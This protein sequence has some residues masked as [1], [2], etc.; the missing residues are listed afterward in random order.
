[1]TATEPEITARESRK[2]DTDLPSES[3]QRALSLALPADVARHIARRGGHRS[4]D[5]SPGLRDAVSTAL[6]QHRIDRVLDL[7]RRNGSSREQRAPLSPRRGLDARGAIALALHASMDTGT[8]DLCDLLGGSP[9]RLGIDLFQARAALLNGRAADSCN[10]PRSL[11]GRL[12]DADLTLQERM[13]LR[14]HLRECPNCGALADRFELLDRDL[15][16]RAE[17]AGSSDGGRDW[18]PWLRRQPGSAFAPAIALLVCLVVVITA[19]AYAGAGQIL[20][21]GGGPIVL[22][23]P[24]VDNGLSGWLV[25]STVDG[26][27]AINL[28]TR[29]HRVLARAPRDQTQPPVTLLSPDGSRI[30]LWRFHDDHRI[31][32][33]LEVTSITGEVLGTWRW[34]RATSPGRLT[35][36]LNDHEL[37]FV[38]P[39]AQQ[40]GE[41]TQD[42]ILRQTEVNQLVALDVDARQIRHLFT[43]SVAL[44][45]PSP[46]Q[47]HVAILGI[48]TTTAGLPGRTLEIRPVAGDNLGD[49]VAIQENRYPLEGTRPIWSEDGSLVFFTRLSD[50]SPFGAA[51]ARR[52]ERV[53]VAMLDL[54]GN[55]A[56][57]TDN[58]EHERVRLLGVSPDASEFL[59]LLSSSTTVPVTWNLW[60]GTVGEGAHDML[61]EDIASPFFYAST[62]TWLP[63]G[64]TA[65]VNESQMHFLNGDATSRAVPV[66]ATRF[67]AIRGD[68]VRVISTELGVWGIDAWGEQTLRWVAEIAPGDAVARTPE[69]IA[70]VFSP[71]EVIDDDAALRL[72]AS[73]SLPSP[74][75]THVLYRHG[76]IDVPIIWS[77]TGRSGRILSGNLPPTDIAWSAGGDAV[78]GVQDDLDYGSRLVFYATQTS[79]VANFF[80]YRALDPAGIRDDP[81]ARYAAPRLAPDGTSIS[82]VILWDDERSGELWIATLDG[83]HRIAH[84]WSTPA[85]A[86][87][88][89]PVLAHWTSPSTI[90]VATPL[91]WRSGYPLEIELTQ[92]SIDAGE[93]VSA[94]RVMTF[95]APG[96][97][98][99]LTLE[100]M[101]FSPDREYLALR[102]RYYGSSDPDRR[103]QD[104]V[105]V[106]SSHDARQSVE[107]TRGDPGH[108][109]A[110]SPDSRWLA[111]GTRDRIAVATVDGRNFRFI[112]NDGERAR[113]PVWDA[114]GQIHYTAGNLHNESLIVVLAR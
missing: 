68:E 107:L 28:A 19:S 4:Q 91:R 65:V 89:Q 79:R 88:E 16:A 12:R 1:M 9:E 59:Y 44:A 42:F 39:P 31:T 77:Q 47:R 78:I 3:L 46:D 92:I 86:K 103:Q 45:T 29:E 94:D 2:R 102:L 36:W 18:L 80:D 61:A 50:V 55:L 71:P 97:E 11:I 81:S 83:G 64:E 52:A 21:I 57:L 17:S 24:P 75:A 111:F 74:T 70:G 33:T 110:W 25:T 13:T 101:V 106:A 22:A 112:S 104:I 113:H 5:G 62:A 37:L 41:S 72:T 76:L 87:V 20:G 43:G 58:V 53:D 82:Y 90:L 7:V 14:A 10:E 66:G 95:R 67:L 8:D 30:A 93:N 109:I 32:A 105:R 49:A 63:D 96:S 73:W 40:P 108:G 56:V 48:Y 99:G 60:R 69:S 15:R 98:R 100:E 27:S 54:E 84:S 26:L 34:D 23:P 51:D 38:M 114:E 35:A 85:D 6:W